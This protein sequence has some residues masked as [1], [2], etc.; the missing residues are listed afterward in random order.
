MLNQQIFEFPISYSNSIPKIVTGWGAHETVA[1]ECKALKMKNVLI[2]SSGLKGT[3]VLDTLIS[4]LKYHGLSAQLF[5]GVTSN[6]KDFQIMEAYRAFKEGECDGVVSLGGGSS[7]DTGKGLRVVAANDGRHI[8]DFAAFIDPPWMEKIKDF[9][10]CTI[11]Q[12]AVT[13]TAGTGAEVTAMGTVTNTKLRTKEIVIVP[14]MGAGTAVIDPLIIRLLPKTF[15]AWTGCDALSHGI[16]AYCTKVQSPYTAGIL[17]RVVQLV[18][19]NLREFTYNRMNHVACERM[20]NAA[21][22]GGIGIAFG[23]G[24]GIIHGLGHQIGA[25]TDCHHGL[26]NALVAVQAEKYNQSSAV[27]KMAEMARAAGVDTRQMTRIQAADKWIAELERLL[28]D[29]EIEPGRLHEQVGLQRADL[30]HVVKTYQN[31]FCSQG[32]PREF[33][34]AEVLKLLEEMY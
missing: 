16:E 8:T 1:D 3:G 18:F 10:A 14:N 25:V 30:E 32:N 15:A 27:E 33:N 28:K 9:K 5:S 6:P 26:A 21:T 7:H 13:T 11:P 31:D 19:E 23:S 17:L 2:V 29:L 34:Y 20:C 4:S 24:A 22:M 12:V